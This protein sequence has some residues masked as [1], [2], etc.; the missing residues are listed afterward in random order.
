[1]EL[2]EHFEK[3]MA[4]SVNMALATCNGTNPNVRVVTFA[5]DHATP[6]KLYFTTFKECAKVAEFE[7][8]PNVACMPLPASPEADA[9]VRIF[10]KVQKS[11]MTMDEVIALIERKHGGD[12]DMLREGAPMMDIYEVCFPQALVTVGVTAP[13]VVV[14]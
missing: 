12:S 8:N 4:E 14:F 5:Y 7:Q 13:E 1:M 2:R 9:Q 11:A 6:G 10:G 3:I